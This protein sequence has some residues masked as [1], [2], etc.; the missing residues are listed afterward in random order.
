MAFDDFD[1]QVPDERSADPTANSPKKKSGCLLAFIAG[2]GLMVF[3]CCGGGIALG[4]FGLNL[5][6]KAVEVELRDNPVLVEK[7]GPVQS[8]ELDWTASFAKDE[9]DIFV[10][11]VQGEKGR[12]EITA[13]CITEDDASEQVKSASLRLPSGETFELLLPEEE[14]EE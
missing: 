12:G 2:G 8:F 6:T 1:Q 10:F 4:V 5:M 9:D 14:I 3:L 13:H 11:Q 7:L